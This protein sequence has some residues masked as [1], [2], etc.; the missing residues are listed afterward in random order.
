MRYISRIWQCIAA[1]YNYDDAQGFAM[2]L[3]FELQRLPGV[4]LEGLQKLTT[5]LS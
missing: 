5:F 4:W 2:Y 1:A 3:G